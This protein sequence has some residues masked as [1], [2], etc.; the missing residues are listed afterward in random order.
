M[1]IG[2][3]MDVGVGAGCRLLNEPRR[4][5]TIKKRNVIEIQNF[6]L[7]VLLKVVLE[8]TLLLLLLLSRK[9]HKI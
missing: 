1:G 6:L 2:I 7:K 4:R 9:S 5:G 3:R 8:E